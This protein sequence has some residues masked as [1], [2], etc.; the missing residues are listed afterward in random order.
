MLG[1]VAGENKV[2]EHLQQLRAKDAEVGDERR[3]R[4]A[5]LYQQRQCASEHAV[6]AVAASVFVLLY[7]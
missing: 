6:A 4:L 7:E 5:H 2:F 1:R 3:I